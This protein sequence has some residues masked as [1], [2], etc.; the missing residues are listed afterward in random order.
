MYTNN[1]IVLLFFFIF[2]HAQI[3]EMHKL[4]W[5]QISEHDKNC[6]TQGFSFFNKTH[7]LESCGMYN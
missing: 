4:K 6:Y 2:I 3:V 7:L 1:K 5:N